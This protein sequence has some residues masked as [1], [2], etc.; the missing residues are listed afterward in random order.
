M[1]PNAGQ[2]DLPQATKAGAPTPV[3][4]KTRSRDEITGGGGAAR[5][6]RVTPNGSKNE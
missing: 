1:P 4:K 3:G 5:S 6:S 2:R